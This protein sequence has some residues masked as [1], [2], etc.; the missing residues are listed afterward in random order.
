MGNGLLC[1][2]AVAA[3]AAASVAATPAT[4]A[5]APDGGAAICDPVTGDADAPVAVVW[6]WNN[7]G[8]GEK[9]RPG[10]KPLS[11]LLKYA[12]QDA[13]TDVGSLRQATNI[14]SA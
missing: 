4:A 1:P 12:A 5:D 8:G 3:A 14:C 9:E 6:G 13:W 7:G 11:M 10:D 2:A